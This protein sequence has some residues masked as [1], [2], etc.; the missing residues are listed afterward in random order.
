VKIKNYKGGKLGHAEFDPAPFGGR[1]R[2]RTLKDALVVHQR[3]QR[4]G[5]LSTKGRS[6]VAGSGKKP[7]KQKHT[8][9]ARAGDRKSPI[10]RGGGTV[11]G[12]KP[13][14]FSTALPAKARRV[15]LCSAIAGKLA[16]DEVVIAEMPKFDKP[17]SK[18]ARQFLADLGTPRRVLVV[19]AEPD[20]I[21]WKSFRNFPGITLRT[22]KDLCAHDVVAGGLVVAESDAM[23][24]LAERVG[25]REEA[26]A[27]AGV[28]APGNAGESG[29]TP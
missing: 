27:L 17:S 4:Q 20:P 7:W 9:R 15:A 1:V 22:A 28:E 8:G 25:V 5:T 11:F 6:E 12:P 3:N 24:L 21:A 16:D 13:R 26:A 19:L 18:T 29:G 23:S 10:W 14:D 2:Y